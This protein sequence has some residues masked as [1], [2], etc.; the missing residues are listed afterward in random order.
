[1]IVMILDEQYLAEHLDSIADQFRHD[2]LSIYTSYLLMAI[3][4]YIAQMFFA[5]RAWRLWHKRTVVLVP[6]LLFAHVCLFS[7]VTWASYSFAQ[8]AWDSHTTGVELAQ[9]VAWWNRFRAVKLPLQLM[10]GWTGLGQ[11]ASR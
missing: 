5:L 3:V 11:L 4:A 7:T 1:M 2:S 6:I 8:P 10:A 9:V